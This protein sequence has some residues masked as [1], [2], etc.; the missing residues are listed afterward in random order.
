ML[1]RFVRRAKMRLAITEVKDN[2]N[3]LN[4]PMN[5]LSPSKAG[6]NVTTETRRH[7]LSNQSLN[8]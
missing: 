8:V 6:K 4:K 3:R 1:I 7:G 2:W 5:E